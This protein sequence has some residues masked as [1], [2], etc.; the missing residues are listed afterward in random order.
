[1]KIVY[2]F[3][4]VAALALICGNAAAVPIVESTD[5]PSGFMVSGVD[6]G[7]TIRIQMDGSFQTGTFIFS[8]QVEFEDCK[9][10]YDFSCLRNGTFLLTADGGE[11]LVCQDWV[12]YPGDRVSTGDDPVDIVMFDLYPV[13]VY[14]AVLSGEMYDDNDTDIF[15]TFDAVLHDCPDEFYIEF[16]QFLGTVDVY[17]D[18]NPVMITEYTPDSWHTHTFTAARISSVLQ[19]KSRF[20]TSTTF[21]HRLAQYSRLGK[22]MQV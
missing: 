20:T 6:D 5:N 22:V 19:S 9:L 3:V 17:L 11:V 16:P 12:R 7:S 14:T 4:I 21:D 2:L 15:L 10:F 8:P 13:V 1:M 18:G